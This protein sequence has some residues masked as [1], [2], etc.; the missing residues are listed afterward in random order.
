MTGDLLLLQVLLA[1]IIVGYLLG[2]IPFAHLAARR[3]G[4]D[5]FSTGSTRAGTANVFWNV[6]RKRGVMV[7]A[8]DALKGCLA[9]VIAKQL[10]VPEQALILAGGAA[11]AGHWKSIFTRFKGGD[12]MTTLLGVTVALVPLLA[13]VGIA[14]GV[15]TVLIRRRSSYRSSFGVAACFASL[16]L[17]S[18]ALPAFSDQRLLVM[19][20]TVLAMLVIFHNVSVHRARAPQLAGKSREQETTPDVGEIPEPGIDPDATEK[21]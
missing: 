10:G 4:V 2:S 9:I 1:S 21:V 5:I 16:L 8:G 17:I 14:I 6:G 11:V 19:E 13:I 3:R 12:G 7:F 15:A 20:L 18:Q